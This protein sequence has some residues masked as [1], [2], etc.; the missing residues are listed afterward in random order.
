MNV[1]KVPIYSTVRKEKELNFDDE[2]ICD[3][4]LIAKT[5]NDFFG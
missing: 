3:D 2:S 5:L 1:L 4:N